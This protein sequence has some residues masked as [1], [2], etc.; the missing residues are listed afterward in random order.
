MS[1]SIQPTV[2]LLRSGDGNDGNYPRY[3]VALRADECPYAALHALII[4]TYCVGSRTRRHVIK[5]LET[6]GSP[7][8]GIN[9]WVHEGPDGEQSFGAAWLTAEL[10]PLDAD[11]IAY[12]EARG[13]RKDWTLREMLD[14]AAWRLYRREA[15]KP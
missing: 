5:H 9:A 1:D 8:Y 3:M 13:H 12:Y 11:E 10:N 7:D 15:R 4:S 2:Y 14:K 6:D